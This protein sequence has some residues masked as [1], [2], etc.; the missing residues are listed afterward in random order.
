MREVSVINGSVVL[1]PEP[2]HRVLLRDSVLG[3]NR[4]L[5]ASA[6]THSAS[7]SL[8]D[9]VEVHA[10]DTSEGVVLDTEVDVLLDTES[11]VACVVS[12]LPVSEK[13]FFLS[14]LSLTLSPRSRISSALSPRTVTCTAI[15]SFL[16][17]LKLRT[18]KRAREGTGFWPERSSSTLEAEWEVMYPW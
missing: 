13:F 16:L 9:D 10:E 7:G 2:F 6:Q 17:M 15:F 1:A 14:S 4:A 8:Q 18:V 3:A 11:E 5:A 12:G